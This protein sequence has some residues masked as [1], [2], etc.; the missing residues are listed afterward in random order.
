[1]SWDSIVSFCL[2]CD[3]SCFIFH[4]QLLKEH[5]RM[6]G[7]CKW[8][9][10]EE[11]KNYRYKCRDLINSIIDKTEFV[12]P[13]TNESPWVTFSLNSFETYKNQVK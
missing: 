8:P 11:A 7:E 6:G 13:I 3:Y 12:L 1:M 4:I 9:T 10:V 2:N 5:Y